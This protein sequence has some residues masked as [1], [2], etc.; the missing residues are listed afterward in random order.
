MGTARN[1]SHE[2]MDYVASAIRNTFKDRGIEVTTSW[3]RCMETDCYLVI[4]APA[5]G[6]AVS[7]S[8]LVGKEKPRRLRITSEDLRE[9]NGDARRPLYIEGSEMWFGPMSPEAGQRSLPEGP[10]ALLE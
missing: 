4:V 5:I 2:L 3:E 7:G 1:R 8:H 9:W 6:A 10:A